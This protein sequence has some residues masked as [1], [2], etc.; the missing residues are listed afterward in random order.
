MINEAA[1]TLGSKRS[2]I[3]E[4]FEFGMAQAKVVGR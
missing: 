4:L 2:Y 3:R 1:Y